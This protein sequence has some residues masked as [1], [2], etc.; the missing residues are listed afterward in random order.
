MFTN[1]EYRDR[2]LY[3]DPLVIERKSPAYRLGVRQLKQWHEECAR[4]RREAAK[5]E[6]K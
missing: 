2:Y 1:H 3:A 4:R 5:K 6:A